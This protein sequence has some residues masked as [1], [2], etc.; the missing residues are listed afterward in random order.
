MEKNDIVKVLAGF[1]VLALL[2][3]LIYYLFQRKTS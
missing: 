1:S 2:L 3:Y